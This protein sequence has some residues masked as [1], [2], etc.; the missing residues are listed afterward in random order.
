MPTENISQ[1]PPPEPA[2]DM[3]H[4]V[5]TREPFGDFFMLTLDNGHTEELGVEDTRLWFK[6][7]GAEMDKIE[8]VL[9]HCWNFYRSEVIIH[10]PKSPPLP[11]L[12]HAPKL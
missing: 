2:P 6:E 8:K 3:V 7:R 5:I 11:L 1:N 9:D 12:P 4:V 10:K